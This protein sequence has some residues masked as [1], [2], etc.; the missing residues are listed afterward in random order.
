MP[1]ATLHVY[2][3]RPPVAVA[4][5]TLIGRPTM[6]VGIVPFGA[7]ESAATTASVYCLVVERSGRN[8]SVSPTFSVN[9]DVPTAVGVPE[10]VVFPGVPSNGIVRPGG[11]AP[12]LTVQ[13]M[14][15]LPLPTTETGAVYGVPT[16]ALGSAAVVIAS[17]SRTM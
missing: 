2:G 1:L 13:P 8:P 14:P 10:I 5:V 16:T 17:L 11:S 15:R 3:A 12:A 9:V 7:A 6:P 4:G